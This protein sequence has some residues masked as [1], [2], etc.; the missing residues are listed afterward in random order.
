MKSLSILRLSIILSVLSLG[1]YPTELKPQP[2]TLPAP[3]V[4]FLRWGINYPPIIPLIKHQKG[5]TLALVNNYH[6]VTA[7]VTNLLAI[8]YLDMSYPPF[9]HRFLDGLVYNELVY[10]LC[11]DN[12]LYFKNVDNLEITSAYCFQEPNHSITSIIEIDGYLYVLGC[13][14]DSEPEQGKVTVDCF[15]PNTQSA[16][17]HI[18]HS[19]F[20][21]NS[22]LNEENHESLHWLSSF[23]HYVTFEFMKHIYRLDVETKDNILAPI[24]ITPNIS[25]FYITD[26][27]FLIAVGSSMWY[28]DTLGSIID[29]RMAPEDPNRIVSNINLQT[30]YWHDVI[31]RNLAFLGDLLIVDLDLF[32]D[33][34]EIIQHKRIIYNYYNG[35]VTLENSGDSEELVYFR[36]NT[37]IDNYLLACYGYDSNP[38]LYE[39]DRQDYSFKI[40]GNFLPRDKTL[41]SIKVWNDTL[42]VEDYGRFWLQIGEENTLPDTMPADWRDA[43]ILGKVAYVFLEGD[44][45]LHLFDLSSDAYLNPIKTIDDGQAWLP[46]NYSA[47][48]A[49][50]FNRLIKIVASDSV[51][52]LGEIKGDN[53]NNIVRAGKYLVNGF[54]HPWTQNMKLNI[55]D[56]SDEDN[57]IKASEI[58]YTPSIRDIAVHDS[59]IYACS[60]LGFS[61]HIIHDG[62]LGDPIVE[63]PN[64]ACSNWIFTSG[65]ILIVFRDVLRRFDFYDIIDPY[66]PILLAQIEDVNTRFI[67]DMAFQGNK[68]YILNNNSL[69]CY[70]ISSII[71]NEVIRVMEYLDEDLPAT[72]PDKISLAPAY[73]NP[74]NGYTKITYY[75]PSRGEGFVQI[76]NILGQVTHSLYKGEM[77]S[78]TH[79][80]IL[81]TNDMASGVYFVQAKWMNTSATQKIV[82]IR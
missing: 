21:I 77:L 4:S 44:Y 68:F 82:L 65:R 20:L 6:M 37:L 41:T 25:D 46:S 79:H 2:A 39:F 23:D 27:N 35:N 76:Y 74:F 22:T 24:D 15:L 81:N 59:I 50:T 31:I 8:Q 60:P 17:V 69:L 19:V 45:D 62:I 28:N 63:D 18:K 55:Y 78:G 75:V 72:V 38:Q 13:Y 7:D 36:D 61:G 58:T 49:P 52:I 9:N 67:S 64:P 26:R 57:I 70:D 54:D 80:I 48:Y 66:N 3:R 56:I 12:T 16:P 5:D 1:I 33:F 30:A 71:D 34:E 51:S 32:S 73:P 40:A 14:L 42:L 29:M 11:D 43:N 10:L 53:H 47:P